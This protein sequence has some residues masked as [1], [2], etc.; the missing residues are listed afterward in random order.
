MYSHILKIMDDMDV[1]DESMG[2]MAQKMQNDNDVLN[3]LRLARR[4]LW[5]KRF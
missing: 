2:F 1:E 5:K 3:I 4:V